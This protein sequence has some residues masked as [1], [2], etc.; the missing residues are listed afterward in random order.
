MTEYIFKEEWDSFTCPE[1]GSD[2]LYRT[3]VLPDE[4]QCFVFFV[5]PDCN[6]QLEAGYSFDYIQ[7]KKEG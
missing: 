7:Y 4:S 2:K 5:C 3:V 1:C 6:L